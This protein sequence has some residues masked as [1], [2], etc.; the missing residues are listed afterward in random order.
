MINNFVYKILRTIKQLL[1]SYSAN[2]YPNNS[3]EIINSDYI[4]NKL[5]GRY[6]EFYY[7]GRIALEGYYNLGLK[8]SIWEEYNIW[9]SLSFR[10]RYKDDLENSKWQYYYEN[11]NIQKTEFYVLGIKNGLN[12]GFLLVAENLLASVKK[13]PS[14]PIP[15]PHMTPALFGSIL[16]KLIF[17]SLKASSATTTA[18]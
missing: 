13:V 4:N 16:L 1:T 6:L 9:N 10:K 8:D 5:N 12:L 15:D 18:K 7:N 17:A 14:P 3:V 2:L 11:G